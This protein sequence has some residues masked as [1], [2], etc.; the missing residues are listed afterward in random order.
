MKSLNVLLVSVLAIPAFAQGSVSDA[1]LKANAELV[2]QSF[3]QATWDSATV[4]E[5]KILVRNA[6][7]KASGLKSYQAENLKDLI[8]VEVRM[9]D[10]GH[11]EGSVIV[12][13]NAFG[14]VLSVIHGDSFTP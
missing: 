13:E 4:V 3:V 11:D 2:A 14:K 6:R 9:I 1:E 7:I 12:Y 8:A 5:S 10:G